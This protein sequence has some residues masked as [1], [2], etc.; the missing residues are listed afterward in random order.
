MMSREGQQQM[1]KAGRIPVRADV[2]PNPPDIV[3]RVQKHKIIAYNFAADQEKRLERSFQ[4]IF[5]PR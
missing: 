5:K 1:T 3:T 2:T 4:E